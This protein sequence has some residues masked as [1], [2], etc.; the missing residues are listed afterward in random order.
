MYMAELKAGGEAGKPAAHGAE[1]SCFIQ[2][3]V[4]SFDFIPNIC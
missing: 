3:F 1:R 4:N 2:T